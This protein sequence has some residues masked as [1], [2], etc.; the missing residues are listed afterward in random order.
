MQ[1][2]TFT[3]NYA[4][5]GSNIASYAIKIKL[6]NSYSDDIILENVGSGVLY[7]QT[8]DFILIDADN[9]TMVLDSSSQ[10]EIKSFSSDTLVSG[11]NAVKANQGAVSFS[12]LYFTSNPG[13][14]N[15]EFEITSKAL[16]TEIL[17]LQFGADYSQ[18]PITV[19]FRYCKPGEI[20]R[21]SQ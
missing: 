2:L 12:S 21:N 18:A 20:I 1:N 4:S 15:V 7:D 9:Q 19:S 6:N 8:L 5:Y 13:D 14:T 11:I 3:N 10:I 16:D 17:K